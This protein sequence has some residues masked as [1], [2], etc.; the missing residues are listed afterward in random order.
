MLIKPILLVEDDLVDVMSVKRSVKHLEIPNPLIVVSNG[1]EALTY[2]R[3]EK[4]PLPVLILLDINMPKLNGIE[5]LRIAKQEE[6]LRRLPVVVLTTSHDDQDRFDSFNVGAA[7]YML[8]PVDFRRFVEV[9][10]TIHEYWTLSE[11]ADHVG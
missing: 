3:D 9:I 7:G 10:R 8:K 11:L 2:L 5:F 4:N 1:E 6:R